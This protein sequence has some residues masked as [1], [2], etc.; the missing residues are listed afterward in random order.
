M[1]NRKLNVLVVGATGSIG[2]LVVE[3]ATRQGH[4]VRALVR[5]ASKAR[6]LPREVKTVVGDLTRPEILPAAVSTRSSSLM[7]RM[8]EARQFLSQ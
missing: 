3:E 4:A 1:T 7:A 2:S 6:Q 5:N 8:A